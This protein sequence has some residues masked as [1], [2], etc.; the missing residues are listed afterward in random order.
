MARPSNST[1]REICD[2]IA[3]MTIGRPA[4]DDNTFDDD[5]LLPADY[6]CL[7]TYVNIANQ[8]A[9]LRM[10]ERWLQKEFSLQLAAGTAYP[11]PLDDT[12]SV[13]GLAY[14][15]FRCTTPGAAR[16]LLAW[17][18]DGGDSSYLA[19]RQAYPDL[20]LL[21]SGPPAAFIII[22]V[23]QAENNAHNLL[24]YPTP[25]QGYTLQY[26]AKINAV[27]LTNHDD[28]IQ[29]PGEHEVALLMMAA[30]FYQSQKGI[31]DVSLMSSVAAQAVE[32]VK[33]WASGALEGRPGQRQSVRFRS[34][35]NT[36]FDFDGT[37]G[38]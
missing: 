12:V 22:P 38:W 35:R 26:L 16:P 20:T 30:S 4:A 28:L 3:K 21:P 14:H 36:R 24:I 5:T 13:E 2:K 18:A 19:F 29:W 33:A 1:Y 6:V 25:D 10:N 32:S 17:S 9:V 37:A 31:L 27:E 23:G 7:K 34:R 11:Y 8:L 15:S